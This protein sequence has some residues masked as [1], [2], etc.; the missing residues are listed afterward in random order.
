LDRLSVSR[1]FSYW[2]NI[3]ITRKE[4]FIRRAWQ[5]LWS[6][7]DMVLLPH[8]KNGIILAVSGGPDSRALLESIA[9]WKH[10]LRGK[11][12]VVIFDHGLREQSKLESQLI[13]MRSQRLGFLTIKKTFFISEAIGES[14]LRE[15][16]YSYL[17][18]IARSS[19]CSSLCTAHHADDNAEGF[20]MSI[21]GF[22]GGH[23]GEAISE[24]SNLE[25]LCL[26]RP[27]S[28]L[29][30]SDLLAP[31]NL[32]R[33]TDYAQ[34]NLDEDMAGRRALVRNGMIKAMIP[35]GSGIKKRLRKFSQKQLEYNQNI[36]LMAKKIICWKDDHRSA[37]IDVGMAEGPAILEEALKLILKKICKNRDLR[38]QS[39]ILSE[40]A[41]KAFEAKPG[42]DHEIKC[43]KLS[44]LKGEGYFFPGAKVFLASNTQMEIEAFGP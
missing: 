10:R 37:V 8:L 1:D 41:K 36:N 14:E 43:S 21:L 42:L 29:S 3:V 32:C 22:G 17:S 11:F 13:A 9:R 35:F 34:D 39:Q 5:K 16:R 33:L 24:V 31:L 25:D 12:I 44:T 2:M 7:L 6:K 15:K 18:A 19:G 30:K 40:I 26:L 27:F 23:L 38:S 4:T 28:S 20:L